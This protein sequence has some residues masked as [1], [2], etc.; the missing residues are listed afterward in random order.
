MIR[1]FRIV[2]VGGSIGGCGASLPDLPDVFHSPFEAEQIRAPHPCCWDVGYFRSH[3][4]L[5]S[6]LGTGVA[7]EHEPSCGGYG[8]IAGDR[9]AYGGAAHSSQ[10]MLE[11][12]SLQIEP[13]SNFQHRLRVRSRLRHLRLR[14]VRTEHEVIRDYGAVAQH[15]VIARG[16][17][18]HAIIPGNVLPEY[19]VL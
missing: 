8:R 13:I 16:S 5:S 14:Q 3:R 9:S 2:I 6:C 4:I 19:G 11:W 15:E 10:Q 12:A 17:L 7:S 1:G 18:V